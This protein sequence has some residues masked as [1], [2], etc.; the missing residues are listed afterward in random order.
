MCMYFCS[1][2]G[3]QALYILGMCFIIELHPWENTYFAFLHMFFFTFAT[4][5][6][7]LFEVLAAFMWRYRVNHSHN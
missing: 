6:A 1:G 5:I 7:H 4:L 3:T 2:Q